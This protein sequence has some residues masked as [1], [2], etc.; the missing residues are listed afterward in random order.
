MSYIVYS[1]SDSPILNFECIGYSK[2]PII[3]KFGPAQRDQY[4]IHYVISGKGY[5]NGHI[6]CKDQGF[7]ITPNLLEHYYP[8]KNDPWEFVWIISSDKRIEC[9]LEGL[10]EDSIS[11]IFNHSAHTEL[12]NIIETIKLNNNRV[13]SSNKILEMFLSLYNS[14]VVAE[15]TNQ[16]SNG[17]IYLDFAVNYIENNISTV[18]SVSTLTQI[19]GISQAYLFKIFKNNFGIS[20]KQYINEV[21]LKK[22]K[23]LLCDTELSITQISASVGF[24]DVLSF[25]KFFSKKVGLSPQNYRKKLNLTT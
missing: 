3:T 1:N 25:S 13:I 11:L 16:K 23:K 15:T 12:K 19:L 18:I 14:N 21:R 4:I 17:E 5:Y 2:N 10:C 9:M 8:D 24:S 6:V 22:A 20:T 7:I